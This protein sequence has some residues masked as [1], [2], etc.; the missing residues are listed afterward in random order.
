MERY[1]G[2]VGEGL[3]HAHISS[4]I[5][6]CLCTTGSTNPV[7]FM[8]LTNF[9]ESNLQ[10]G[11]L[12]FKVSDSYLKLEKVKADFHSLSFCHMITLKVLFSIKLYWM[13]Q[14]KSRGKRK[15]LLSILDNLFKY[16]FLFCCCGKWG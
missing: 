5:F 14:S 4:I 2:K 16:D 1:I 12:H 7:Q 13:Q 8:M 15:W 9:S 10:E 3:L 6:F 11:I